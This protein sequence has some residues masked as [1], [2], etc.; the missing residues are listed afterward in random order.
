MFVIRFED[1]CVG[2]CPQGCIGSSCLNRHLLFLTCD[3]CGYDV[4]ELYATDNGQVCLDCLREMFS[5]ITTDNAEDYV[6]R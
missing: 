2:P 6:E 3:K 1:G 5:C 4:D